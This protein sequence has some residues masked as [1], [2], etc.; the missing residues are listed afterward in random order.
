MGTEA[1]IS[2]DAVAREKENGGAHVQSTAELDA[3]ALF[4]LKS[5]GSWLHCGY[6]LTTSIVAPALLS[7]PFALSVL[8]WVGGIIS[9]LACGFLTF[10]SYNLLSIVLEHHAT[11]GTRLLRFRDMATFILGTFSPFHYLQNFVY[12]EYN[13]W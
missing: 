6:H 8:G 10:Y 3:G 9:L 7:L 5:R 2:G 11:C 1:Q 4:V 13:F 12:Y